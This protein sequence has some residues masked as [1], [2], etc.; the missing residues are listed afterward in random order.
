MKKNHYFGRQVRDMIKQTKY[1][2]DSNYNKFK[3]ACIYIRL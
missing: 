1:D 2:N 3:P